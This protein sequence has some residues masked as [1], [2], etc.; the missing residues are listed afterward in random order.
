MNSVVLVPKSSPPAA[1]QTPIAVEDWE[2][3]FGALVETLGAHAEEW[4]GAPDLMPLIASGGAR[5][6][7]MDSLAALRQLKAT[8]ALEANTR[9]GLRLEVVDARTALT[10][11]LAEESKARYLSL[12][13][14]LTTLPNRN[15]FHNRLDR[16]ISQSD[17]GHHLLAVFYIDLDSFKPIND[18]HGHGIGDEL[19]RIV[20]ARLLHAVRADD[21]VS[22]MGG[23]EFAC[24]L[25]GSPSREHLSHL[26]C[27][28]L[29]SVSAPLTIGNLELVVRPSIGIAVW[30]ADGESTEALLK[31][32]DAAM[33]RAKQQ[34]TGYAFFDEEAIA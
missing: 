10:Q 17:G 1:T 24:L 28:L 5:A 4:L 23:D 33:Y 18:H 20:A 13:D 14:D 11:A 21:L 31:S 2:A 32:A 6:S 19:L 15:F 30:P 29:D 7:L 25:G 27:K 8:L 16:F 12:H 26:A 34:K 9:R 22:R 3:M